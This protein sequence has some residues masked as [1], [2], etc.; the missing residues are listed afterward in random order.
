[1]G[2]GCIEKREK[3]KLSACT[4]LQLQQERRRGLDPLLPSDKDNEMN[5]CTASPPKNNKKQNKKTQ[6]AFT[7]PVVVWSF[8]HDLKAVH[9]V[10]PGLLQEV[11]WQNPSKKATKKKHPRTRARPCCSSA[12]ACDASFSIPIIYT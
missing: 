5:T 4:V 3:I 9:L 6:T 8:R 12:R 10:E 1:M 7:N 11:D 2:I